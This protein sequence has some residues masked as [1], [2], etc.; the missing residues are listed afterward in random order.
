[1][2]THTGI[3]VVPKWNIHVRCMYAVRPLYAE[4]AAMQSNCWVRQ[5]FTRVNQMFILWDVAP[6]MGAL[7]SIDISSSASHA[8]SLWSCF[9]FTGSSV[10]HFD[11]RISFFGLHLWKFREAHIALDV[12]W[13]RTHF[14]P[15]KLPMVVVLV[16]SKLALISCC[17]HLTRTTT[18]LLLCGG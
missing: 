2:F 16:L 1:M 4:L 14:S 12:C 3:P 17:A 9:N 11:S 15:I 7:I 10:T 18:S 13:K 6:T 5:V 8:R